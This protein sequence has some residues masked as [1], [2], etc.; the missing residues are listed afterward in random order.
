MKT[1]KIT[2]IATMIAMIAFISF[3][4]SCSKEK[5]SNPLSGIQSSSSSNAT[6]ASY[7]Y[8]LG[9][10]PVEGPDVTAASN[11]DEIILTGSGTFSTNP[12]SV[13]GGGTFVHQDAAGNVL[14]TGTWSA[15]Q[16]SSFVSYGGDPSLPPELEGGKAI[17]QVHLSPDSGGTGFDGMLQIHCLIGKFPKGANEGIRL[18]VQSLGSNFNK[19]VEGETLF[20]LQ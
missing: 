5:T 17:I 19:E 9:E 8:I 2:R 3:M 16:L 4:V 6:T 20:I 13:S 12:K 7:S 11:G 10:E 15:T 14:A 1:T 18:S